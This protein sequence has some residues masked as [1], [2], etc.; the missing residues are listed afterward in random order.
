M[1]LALIW[2]W[3]EVCLISLWNG[4]IKPIQ[5]GIPQAAELEVYILILKSRQQLWELSGSFKLCVVMN[6]YASMCMCESFKWKNTHCMY[7]N[8][9]PP[10]RA[11]VSIPAHFSFSPRYRRVQHFS[12]KWVRIV[13]LPTNPLPHHPGAQHWVIASQVLKEKERNNK[14][15]GTERKKLMQIS[16]KMCAGTSDRSLNR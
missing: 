1:R 13:F 5:M 15:E 16:M 8:H 14:T 3:V 2:N 7:V 6:L 10:S 12:S 11:A 9:Q 4:I